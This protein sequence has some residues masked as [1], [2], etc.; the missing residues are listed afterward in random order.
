MRVGNE[1]MLTRKISFA[2]RSASFSSWALWK[3][4]MT[5]ARSPV[6]SLR[7]AQTRQK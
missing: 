2:K 5:A 1:D 6:L 4:A 3:T 7:S